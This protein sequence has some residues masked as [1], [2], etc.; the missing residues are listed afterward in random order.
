MTFLEGYVDVSERLEMFFQAFPDGSLQ[1]WEPP[2]VVEI[3]GSSFIQYSAAAFRTPD[4][5]RPGI[6]TAWE[7]V[8]GLNNY[9]RNSEL[10]NAET[11][12]W[13]RAIIAIGAASTKR[14]VASRQE[15]Q[16]REGWAQRPP[17]TTAA[18]LS[19]DDPDERKVQNREGRTLDGHLREVA[20]PAPDPGQEFL[21]RASRV[22]RGLGLG[23]NSKY[24]HDH[25]VGVDAPPLWLKGDKRGTRQNLLMAIDAYLMQP[26][27]NLESFAEA[28]LQ[29]APADGAAK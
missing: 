17:S 20:L 21:D 8:P 3:A 14:G 27:S 23:W 28:M 22:L 7:P 11:S 6:G 24:V 18:T 4:D 25:L 26:D 13:G 1:P 12:A 19:V 10:M 9:T 15:V 5:E 16:N 29:A 2:K